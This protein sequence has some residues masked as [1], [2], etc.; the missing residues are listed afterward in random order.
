MLLLLVLLALRT[1]AA[2]EHPMRGRHA[3]KVELSTIAASTAVQLLRGAA[4]LPRPLGSAQA[5]V[6][7]AASL[8]TPAT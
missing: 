4:R 8:R 3:I 6:C 2:S 7:S 1:A 5:A